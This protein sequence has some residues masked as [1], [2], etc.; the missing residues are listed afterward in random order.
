MTLK[1]SFCIHFAHILSKFAQS[2]L[3]VF[4]FVTDLRVYKFFTEHVN[5]AYVIPAAG[6]NLSNRHLFCMRFAQAPLPRD[7]PIF[8]L[9]AL[10]G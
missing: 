5:F 1:S 3:F 9:G 2:L 4:L 7:P 6:N 10:F 8:V